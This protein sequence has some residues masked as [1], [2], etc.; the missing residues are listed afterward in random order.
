MSNLSRWFLVSVIL[1]LVVGGTVLAQTP[2]PA[3]TITNNGGD[4]GGSP[5]ATSEG[6]SWNSADFGST[7]VITNISLISTSTPTAS[8]TIWS[9]GLTPGNY[10]SG[11]K[12]F[13]VTSTASQVTVYLN[14]TAKGTFP[15]GYYRLSVD[16]RDQL[17]N[18]DLEASSYSAGFQLKPNV[19]CPVTVRVASGSGTAYANTSPIA[20]GQ[21]TNIFY[22]PATNYQ[23]SSAR[24][25]VG[26]G[27]WTNVTLNATGGHFT[28]PACT[29]SGNTGQTITAE[30]NFTSAGGCPLNITKSPTN[31]GT[32]NI[33][34]LV[35][36]KIPAGQSS[37]ITATAN[38]GY[39][40]SSFVGANSVSGNVATVSCPTGSTATKNLTVNFTASSC[41]VTGTVTGGNG[42]ITPT[43][44]T[45][46]NG[47]T[48]TFT[49]TADS[50]FV[51]DTFTVNNTAVPNASGER[52]KTSPAV[53][54]ASPNPIPANVTFRPA[55]NCTIIH[56]QPSPSAIGSIS[57][58]TGTTVA[59]NATRSITATARNNNVYKYIVRSLTI[60]GQTTNAPANAT[61]F[62]APATCPAT[63]S[64]IPVSA[65]FEP[66]ACNLSTRVDGDGGRIS[67]EGT[68]NSVPTGTAGLSVIATPNTGY[69][70][71]TFTVPGDTRPVPTTGPMDKK[72]LCTTAGTNIEAVVK[73]KPSTTCTFTATA[74]PTNG[75]TVTLTPTNGIVQPNQNGTFNVQATNP[76]W[77][78]KSFKYRIDRG[79]WQDSRV[80][81]NTTSLS[82]SVTCP[83]T[84]GAVEGVAEFRPATKN[85]TFTATARPTE[86][87]TM[88]LDPTSGVVPIGKDWT[89]KGV[90]TQPLWFIEKF[91]YRII[92]DGKFGDWQES[93]VSDPTDPLDRITTF[94]FGNMCPATGGIVEGEMI[95][96]H[97]LQVDWSITT[98][99]ESEPNNPNAGEVRPLPL[100]KKNYTTSRSVIFVV[101]PNKAAGYVLDWVKLDGVVIEPDDKGRYIVNYDANKKDRTLRARFISDSC[102]TYPPEQTIADLRAGNPAQINTKTFREWLGQKGTYSLDGKTYTTVEEMVKAE[103]DRGQCTFVGDFEKEY[104]TNGHFD[105]RKAWTIYIKVL[106]SAKPPLALN[107]PASFLIIYPEGGH[108]LVGLS[109]KEIPSPVPGWVG[110]KKYEIKYINSNGPKIEEK[111]CREKL[112]RNPLELGPLF[113]RILQCGKGEGQYDVFVFQSQTPDEEFNNWIATMNAVRPNSAKW[114]EK[115][116]TKINNFG[117]PSSPDGNCRG[118]SEFNIRAAL[119]VKECPWKGDPSGGGVGISTVDKKWQ[120]ASL[121]QATDR[122]SDFVK[123]LIYNLILN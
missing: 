99:I 9:S 34:N 15:I 78:I 67:P 85:C 14:G 63:G 88:T 89:I 71:D 22:N 25:Q 73:F 4:W 10:R 31:G 93:T 109:L 12:T 118:W 42:T 77:I 92:V 32:V 52:S 47:Q 19:T 120:L 106:R 101:E 74:T 104:Y 102:A 59:P 62:T 76:N 68:V 72:A 29:A 38:T 108:A 97:D 100:G 40:F 61:T 20:S 5:T 123:A 3:A 39:T 70:I 98:S 2:D 66:T 105:Y 18:P 122:F 115:N 96:N 113:S 75:G 79:A 50:G 121:W 86:G 21:T 33:T 37:N 1:T 36:G 23:A 87:G 82:P 95:F 6:V 107:R 8:A 28:S 53:T 30:V 26:S 55:G 111:T 69:A 17:L 46:T 41:L 51:I 56:N 84:G 114:I 43:T 49:A 103:M 117:S 110:A 45:K 64:N 94:S 81:P 112:M 27:S 60:A 7:P 54:C 80:A 90:A 13:T 65:V 44:G 83:A 35:N 24:Y 58:A 91:R 16:I 116:Y 57:P 119:L 11:S 48:Q